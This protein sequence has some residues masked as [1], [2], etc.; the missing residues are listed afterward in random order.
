MS[1]STTLKLKLQRKSVR[2]TN[3]LDAQAAQD[4]VK[5]PLPKQ[6]DMYVQVFNAQDTMYTDQTGAFPVTSSH[7]HKYVIVMC[8][9]DGNHIDAEPMKSKTAETCCAHTLYYEND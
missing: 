4:N 5:S 6:N 2:S 9:V 8:E 7:G 1:T 3:K